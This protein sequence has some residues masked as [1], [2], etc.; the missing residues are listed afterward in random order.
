MRSKIINKLFLLLFDTVVIFIAFI[1]AYFFRLGTFF[2]SEFIFSEYIEISF[3]MIPLWIIFLAYQGRYCLTEK[4]FFEKF[5][6]I[7]IGSLLGSLLFPL[8]FYFK[9]EVFFSR[10]IIV[11]LFFIAVT[12]LFSLSYVEKKISEYQAKHNIQMSRMLVIGANKNAEAIIEKL[13]KNFSHHKPVA[14]LTPYGSKKSHISEVPILGKLDALEKIFLSENIDEIFLCEGI[15]HSE[16]LSSFCRNK[17]IPLRTSFETLGI[18]PQQT[19]AENIEGT[20]FLSIYQSPL[21]GWGQFYKRIFDIIISSIGLLIFSPYFFIYRKN[22]TTEKFQ[23]GIEESSTFNGY[24]FEKEAINENGKKQKNKKIFWG[25]NISLLINVLK[26]DMS[27]VG[28]KDLMHDE[29]DH[30][31]QDKKEQSAIRFILRP[32]IFSPHK[33]ECFTPEKI[34]RSEISYI[35]N[36]S[37]WGDLKIFILRIINQYK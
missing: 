35:K 23:N 12:L 32:G 27:I 5:N 13:I 29:Y 14:I 8:I 15:E 30:I 33:F 17:G 16:N 6:I 1:S 25:H 24:V 34:L 28:P 10:G 31:F 2:H 36:W 22:L 21:F 4:T 18:S 9:N 7:L 20:V 26:K 3:L 19:Q 11:I 37:F